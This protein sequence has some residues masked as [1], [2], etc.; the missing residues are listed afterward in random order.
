[1]DGVPPALG[2]FALAREP[3]EDDVEGHEIA[4]DR[5]GRFAA[6]D[7]VP[8]GY[9]VV[10][11]PRDVLTRPG[12]AVSSEIALVTA[13]ATTRQTFHLRTQVLRIALRDANG[14]PAGATTCLVGFAGGQFVAKTDEAGVLVLEPA[15]ATPLRLQVLMDLGEDRGGFRAVG[16][17]QAAEGQRETRVEVTLPGAPPSAR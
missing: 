4:L 2:G 7:L 5:E 13:G 6:R 1:M 14:G 10:W 8:A 12:G 17:V 3:G 11:T 9:R 15:P 16:S